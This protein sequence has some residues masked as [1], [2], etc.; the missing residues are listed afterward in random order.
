[1]KQDIPP[2]KTRPAVWIGYGVKKDGTKVIPTKMVWTTGATQAQV[3][4][5]P[6]VYEDRRMTVY[7]AGSWAH[8][9]GRLP[10]FHTEEADW[11]FVL[12]RYDSSI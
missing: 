1:V 4:I 10:K 8:A 3:V 6:P 12:V 7:Q 5:G 2:I 9:E 11:Y